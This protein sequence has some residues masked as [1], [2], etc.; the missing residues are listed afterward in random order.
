[1]VILRQ[2]DEKPQRVP[3]IREFANR[4]GKAGEYGLSVA[5]RGSGRQLHMFSF[6]AEDRRDTKS[7]FVVVSTVPFWFGSRYS[8]VAPNYSLLLSDRLGSVQVGAIQTLGTDPIVLR[9]TI[10]IEVPGS[11]F[12]LL[13]R[14]P[15][16]GA[17]GPNTMVP[18]IDP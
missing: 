13:G 7:S 5:Q 8:L 6:E 18:L 11:N 3:G 9:A 1:M 2:F 4:H 10:P 12:V 17:S 14:P 15:A 16:S